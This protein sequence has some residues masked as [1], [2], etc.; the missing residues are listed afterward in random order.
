[1]KPHQIEHWK[2]EQMKTPKFNTKATVALAASI[3]LITGCAV[4]AGGNF[5]P[6]KNV[7]TSASELEFVN[8][9]PAIKMAAAY[10][11]RGEG[12]HGSF[13]QFPANFETP[14]HTHTG[15][16]HGIVIKGVMTNPF[17][18]EAHPPEMVAG[19]YWYVPAGSPHLTACVSDEPCEFYFYADSAFDFHPTE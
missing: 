15:A 13:G 18:G 8:I 16:Y 17:E 1:M 14:M 11:N 4:M 2:E 12:A 9:N 3:T 7:A 10:G 5:D 6:D 19:S